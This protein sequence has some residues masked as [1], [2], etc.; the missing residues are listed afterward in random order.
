MSMGGR[1]KVV[2]ALDGAGH[3]EFLGR[4]DLERLAQF[5]EIVYAAI[6][7]GHGTP[8]FRANQDPRAVAAVRA[9]LGDADALVVCHG[10]PRVDAA[11]LDAAPR[12]R[13]VG[14]LEGD[15][16][17]AR[18]DVEEAWRRGIVAVDTTNGSSYPVSEWALALLLVSMRSGGYYFR[19][20]LETRTLTHRERR[21]PVPERELW[22]A[23]VGLIGCGHI[24]RRLISFLRPFGC[25]IRVCDPYL[26]PEMADALGF[27]L[28]SLEGVLAHSDAVVCLAPL[29]PGTEHLLGRQE[30][31]LLRP[32]TSFVNVSRGAVVDTDALVERLRRGDITAG[33][34]VFDPEPIPVDHPIKALPNVFLTPHIASHTEATRKRFFTLMVDELKRF[35]EGDRP[36]FELTPR[37]LANRRAAPVEAGVTT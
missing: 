24:G 1:P 8:W 9:V 18:I 32:G 23:T 34:D 19:R 7:E 13:F 33:L 11:L 21:A 26:S 37:A 22:G 20:L 36:L 30:L 16:F 10:A 25:E 27:T 35:F 12:L 14:E 3:D 15:R 28:T 4:D 5:A 29:T 2:L 6:P 31:D 17:A